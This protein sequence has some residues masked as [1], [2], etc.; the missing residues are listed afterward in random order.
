MTYLPCKHP[1]E[2]RKNYSIKP[3]M[4]R[5]VRQM[6]KG[7]HSR[8]GCITLGNRHTYC[9]HLWHFHECSVCGLW[10]SNINFFY[11]NHVFYCKLLVLFL[12]HHDPI[13]EGS[14]PHRAMIGCF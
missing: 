9:I 2:F 10:G 14:S 4:L 11:L 5:M 1:S 12:D 7:Q 8:I 3:K 6:R 13:P